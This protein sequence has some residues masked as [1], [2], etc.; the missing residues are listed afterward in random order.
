MIEDALA[1]VFKNMAGRGES[2]SEEDVEVVESAANLKKN[3]TK[4]DRDNNPRI[5]RRALNH[6]RSKSYK[7]FERLSKCNLHG[8]S[9]C[10]SAPHG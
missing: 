3:S 2:G 10:Q 5:N 8:R 4:K 9:C 7:Y 6:V 1:F